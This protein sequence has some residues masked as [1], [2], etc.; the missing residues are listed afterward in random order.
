MLFHLSLLGA[1]LGIGGALF[2]ASGWMCLVPAG[3]L[4][5]IF[6]FHLIESLW[7]LGSSWG[8]GWEDRVRILVRGSGFAMMSFAILLLPSYASLLLGCSGLLTTMLGR[9]CWEFALARWRKR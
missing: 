4:W 8:L 6:F 1:S 2:E 5:S 3:V 7:A 9:A